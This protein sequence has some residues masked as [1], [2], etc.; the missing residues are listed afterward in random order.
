MEVAPRWMDWASIELGWG[1]DYGA[2]SKFHKLMCTATPPEW[3]VDYQA[4][5][6]H[7]HDADYVT[8]AKRRIEYSSDDSR[9]ST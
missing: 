7:C 5:A 3:K 9:R 2:E 8:H 4:A 1:R 6:D